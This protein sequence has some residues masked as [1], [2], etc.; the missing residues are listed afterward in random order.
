ML[1]E[2]ITVHH[3][4]LGGLVVEDLAVLVLRVGLE[5][6]QVLVEAVGILAA[7][8][9]RFPTQHGHVGHDA[10]VGRITS[11]NVCYTKLLRSC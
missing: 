9:F 2:V 3:V 4:G 1:Y 5:G 7:R 8:Y 6:R 11:Y 10:R